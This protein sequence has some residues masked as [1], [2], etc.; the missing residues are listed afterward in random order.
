MASR[1][2]VVL[3]ISHQDGSGPYASVPEGDGS[4]GIWAER[5]VVR[6]RQRDG[7]LGAGKTGKGVGGIVREA[8]SA[9]EKVID[10]DDVFKLSY[11]RHNELEYV[12]FLPHPHK[13]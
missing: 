7:A 2:Y 12:A 10:G 8:S 6:E 9:G 13:Y 3:S 1:G 11:L 4:C 5:G